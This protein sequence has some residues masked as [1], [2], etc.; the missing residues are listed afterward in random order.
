MVDPSPKD[1]TGRDNPRSAIEC[2]TKD[3]LSLDS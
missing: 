1:A 3:P 2:H